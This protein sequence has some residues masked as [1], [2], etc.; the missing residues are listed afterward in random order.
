ML[1]SQQTLNIA[2]MGAATLAQMKVVQMSMLHSCHTPQI[3]GLGV[4]V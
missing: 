4:S 2:L 1:F 3:Y